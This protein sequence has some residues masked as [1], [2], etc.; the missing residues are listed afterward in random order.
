MLNLNNKYKYVNQVKAEVNELFSA[1]AYNY[2]IQIDI[3][4]VLAI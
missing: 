4:N 1:T 2:L 3:L